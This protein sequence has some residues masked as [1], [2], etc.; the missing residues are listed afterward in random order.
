MENSNDTPAL[1]PHGQPGRLLPPV[2]AFRR[3]PVMPRIAAGVAWMSRSAC[4]SEDPELFFPVELAGPALLE[5][6][7]TAKA[8]CGRCLVRRSCLSYA[9][10]TG[11]EG[12][13][14]GTTTDER[15][16][17]RRRS[18]AGSGPRAA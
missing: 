17:R 18:S 15:R 9:V 7:S 5:R 10:R 3:V 6:I 16:R 1:P 11:Q 14:G 13:W 4:R 12:I 8:V 2:V